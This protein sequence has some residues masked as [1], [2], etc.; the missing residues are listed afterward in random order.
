MTPRTLDRL[1]TDLHESAGRLSSI[2]PSLALDPTDRATLR[3]VASLLRAWAYW[4]DVAAKDERDHP[5]VQDQRITEIIE[6]LQA[7][8]TEPN[9]D[10]RIAS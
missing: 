2:A 6:Q 3:D 8:S 9:E 4:A 7:T 5:S 1:A 10:A